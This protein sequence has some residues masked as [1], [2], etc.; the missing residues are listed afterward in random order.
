LDVPEQ[1][2]VGVFQQDELFQV[3]SVEA[4]RVGTFTT[5]TS[6]PSSRERL[7]EFSLSFSLLVLRYVFGVEEKLPRER[8]IL[9]DEN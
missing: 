2:R 4:S 6:M 3:W 7:D 1:L 9:V 5:F 8:K